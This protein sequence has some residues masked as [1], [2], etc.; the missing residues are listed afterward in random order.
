M[1]LADGCR[2]T[3]DFRCVIRESDESFVVV[4]YEV[5]AQRNVK[6]KDKNGVVVVSRKAFS[7]E[8]A[9]VKLKI[10]AKEYPE[11]RW[12]VVSQNKD[13]SWLEDAVGAA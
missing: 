1:R 2:Y 4:F 6:R 9:K 10:A 8:D 5:K 11:Y 7:E 13:G 12:V 3:P